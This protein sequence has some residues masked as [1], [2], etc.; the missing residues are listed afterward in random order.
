MMVERAAYQALGG[1]APIRRSL[2]DGLTLPR[3]FRRAG[4]R[5]DIAAGW[6]LASCRMY[7]RFDEA[8]RGFAKNAREGMARPIG[9]PVW[10]LL[11]GGAHILPPMLLAAA[12]IAGAE[13]LAVQAAIAWAL[14]LAFRTLTSLTV[15]E[16][17][18]PVLVTPAIVAVGLAIQWQAL[19]RDPRRNGA[20]WRG[21]RYDLTADAS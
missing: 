3:L 16:G 17:W 5:T 8:W 21:R 12:L 13:A 1:H 6:P 15:R 2:H 11:L 9:L 19:L 7:G 10:T 4:H 20:E 14:S 18:L